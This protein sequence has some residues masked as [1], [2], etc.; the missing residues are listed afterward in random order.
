LNICC[1]VTDGG[2][3]NADIVQHTQLPQFVLIDCIYSLPFNDQQFGSILCSHTM[4]HVDDPRLFFEELQRIGRN[5]TL[6]VP[7]LWDVT[8]AFNLLEHKHLFLTCR[9]RHTCLPRYVRLPLAD[10][11]HRRWRQTI[12]A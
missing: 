1:G 9:T 12:R 7:P 11:I 3:T 2:G 10:V 6:V 8:A 4:E 5:I